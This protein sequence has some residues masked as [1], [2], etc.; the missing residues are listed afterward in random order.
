MTSSS[1]Y[2]IVGSGVVAAALL[3]LWPMLDPLAREGIVIAAL[4]ALP[5]QIVS[6]S[7]LVRFRDR[8]RGFL[9]AWVGGTVAR[10]LAI[11]TVAYLVLRSS[12]EGALTVLVALAAFLFALLLL[13]PI[14]FKGSHRDVG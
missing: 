2:A 14:Y 4:V 3:L 12:A 6:F 7:L 13:E 9:A 1:R 11:G 10:V 5:V 8:L